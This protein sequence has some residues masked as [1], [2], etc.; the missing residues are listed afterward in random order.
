MSI[1]DYS[2]IADNN[3]TISGLSIAEGCPPSNVN[4]AMRQIMADMKA[5]K[6][7]KDA[8]VS[9]LQSDVKKLQ[10][11]TA[12]K[13]FAKLIYPVGTIY[14]S[15]VATSPAT[16]FGGTWERISGRFLWC[17]DDSEASTAKTGGAAT[18]TLSQAQMP[19]HTH[20]GSTKVAGNHNHTKGS[21]RIWGSTFAN[22]EFFQGGGNGCLRTVGW[23]GS[24]NRDGDYDHR[25]SAIELDTNYGGWTGATAS[26]GDHVHDVTVNTTGGGQEHENMPPYLAVYAWKRTA[27]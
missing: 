13:A 9:R 24:R 17:G 5:E 16:L 26:A 10:D 6:D 21:M 20:T 27:L 14:F 7:D 8:A 22:S 4:N 19:N 3:I 15:T 1:A 25:V 18:V 11:D 12:I 2:T 23:T